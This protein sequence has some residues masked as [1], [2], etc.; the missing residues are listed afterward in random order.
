MSAS[1]QTGSTFHP[2]EVSRLARLALPVALGEL[3]WATMGTVDL[4]MAGPLGD[5]AIGAIGLGNNVF[6][7]FGLMGIGLL[8]GLDTLVSQAYGAGNRAD[9]RHSLTQGLWLATLIGVPMIGFFFFL[10]P[11]F[12][13]VGV[14]EPVSRLA[15]QYLFVLSFSALPLGYYT[16]LRRYLQGLGHVRAV[17]FALVSANVV[18]W[19]FN[20]L[21][22]QGHWG[23]P[24]LGVR[25]SALSTVIARLYMAATLAIAA[26][27]LQ[28]G[29]MRDTRPPSHRPDWQRIRTLIRIGSPA[30]TQILLEIGAFG[31]VGVL[32]GR[33]N[34]V[35]LAAHQ[36]ALNC[37]SMTFMVPLGIS[38]AAAVAVGHAAGSGDL[39]AAKRAG[40]IAVGLAS[41]FMASAAI[42]F[43]ASPHA[44]LTLY[45]KDPPT[46][47][48]G[49]G[50]LAIAAAFQLFDGIQVVLTGA[51]RGIGDTRTPMLMNLAA[52]YGFGLPIGYALCFHFGY[53]VHGL[54]WGLTVA[55][56]F[57]A[58]TLAFKWSRSQAFSPLLTPAA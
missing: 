24:A 6:Y 41:A 47:A 27:A 5:A 52:Y 57:V 30:A 32:A 22:I 50:L 54:W 55:L 17:M 39:A 42:V 14:T 13:L 43:L 31:I 4:V 23:F 19:F 20:W 1:R 26:A 44:I 40:Y 28:R 29:E 3:G 18:N 10:R 49:A 33:L 46:L 21:L 7:T 16:A 38:S 36:I 15:A 12:H 11:I 37:A 2:S 56:A 8:L 48:F 35:A 34:E 58:I 51:L 53:G 9:C 45:T 25:G